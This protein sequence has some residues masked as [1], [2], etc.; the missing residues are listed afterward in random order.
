ML[1]A[2]VASDPFCPKITNFWCCWPL[3]RAVI[4][5]NLLENPQAILQWLRWIVICINLHCNSVIPAFIS[6]DWNC[7]RPGKGRIQHPRHIW[8]DASPTTHLCSLKPLTHKTSQ[9]ITK[10]YKI[11]QSLWSSLKA[12]HFWKQYIYIHRFSLLRARRNHRR[13]LL[14]L[15]KCNHP[16]L[17]LS[18]LILRFFTKTNQLSEWVTKAIIKPRK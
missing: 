11:S 6:S 7:R 16:L 18:Q 5:T 3:L 14:K 17:L 9:N 8:K 2:F 1:N 15:H 4:S 13:K 12:T 10:H